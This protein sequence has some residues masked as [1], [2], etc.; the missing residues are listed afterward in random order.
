MCAGVC[1]CTCLCVCQS[2]CV[3]LHSVTM[4][5]SDQCLC[6]QD[7]MHVPNE[8][9]TNVIKSL[10]TLFPLGDDGQQKSTDAISWCGSIL[11]NIRR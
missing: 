4:S 8:M 9:Y 3:S 6:R 1:V 7:I 2:L 10:L 5:M 11:F